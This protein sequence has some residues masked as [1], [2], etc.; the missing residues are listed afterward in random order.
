MRSVSDSV[1]VSR[2][3]SS[4]L[5]ARGCTT[6]LIFAGVVAAFRIAAKVEG[7]ICCRAGHGQIGETRKMGQPI[8]V[9]HDSW[10]AVSR[11]PTR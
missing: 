11:G 10:S 3:N 7:V 9:R 5:V 8:S 2:K 1:I 6:V 4:A